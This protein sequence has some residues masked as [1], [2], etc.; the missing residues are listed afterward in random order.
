MSVRGELHLSGNGEVSIFQLET[1]RFTIGR[2]PENT[3]CV[4]ESVVSRSHAELIRIGNDFLLRDLGS[5][6]GS[7]VNGARVSEQMLNDGD[8]LRF[9][10][11]GPEAT[12]KLIEKETGE[13]IKHQRHPKSTTETLIGSLTGKLEF[14]Q[15]DVC[16]EANLRRVLAEAHLNKGEH[17]RAL[18]VLAKYN[19]TTNLIAL[20]LSFRATLLLW[21]GRVYL[22]R[23]QLDI[24]ID[25]LQ[26]SLNFYKQASDGKGD[27]TGIA[28][29]HASLGRALLNSGDFLAARENLHRGMLAAR[30]AGNVRLRAEVHYLLGKVDW[31]EGDFEG[32][33]Y[34]WGRSARMA[35]E[36]NDALLQGR[37]QLQ[38]ALVLYTEGK[39]KEA[40]PAYQ[41]AIQQ[42]ESTGNVRLL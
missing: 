9:G 41:A 39:L 19:D 5:T 31:K 11:N 33:R 8:L 4:P 21:I 2:G 35:E 30:R 20:P 22:E 26:R 23:K 42:I 13:I 3:L 6:N 28:S 15:Y 38:Q 12:F 32:A 17:D 36:T 29:V 18:E 37:V 16:E 10:N 1:P 24:A 34:N 14:P 7:F 27:E 25:A 40:V